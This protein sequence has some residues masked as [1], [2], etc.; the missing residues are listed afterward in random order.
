MNLLED[1]KSQGKSSQV[2]ST[3]AEVKHN[4]L[5][6]Y[7]SSNNAITFI[8]INDDEKA[9]AINKT[10]EGETSEVERR[11][12]YHFSRKLSSLDHFALNNQ[13]VSTLVCLLTAIN[14]W[15]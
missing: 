12:T 8:D 10:G 9:Q 1:M 4:F 11:M 13:L 5:D 7:D 3:S 15:M 14:C 2:S 6:P